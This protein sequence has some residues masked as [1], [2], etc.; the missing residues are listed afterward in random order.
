MSEMGGR[1]V[2]VATGGLAPLFL[3]DLPGVRHEPDLTLHGLRFAHDILH[4]G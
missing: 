1:P 4:H 3:G 2:V